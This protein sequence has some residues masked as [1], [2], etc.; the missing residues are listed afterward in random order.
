MGNFVKQ[1]ISDYNFK[2]NY[3]LLNNPFV[4]HE[5]QKFSIVY[6]LLDKSLRFS[7]FVRCITCTNINIHIR[8]FFFH[9]VKIFYNCEISIGAKF[10]L[11]LHFPHP[12]NIIIGGNA[13][14]KNKVVIFHSVTVG[15][16]N[17]GMTGG[18]PSFGNNIV[19]G[20]GSA[21]LGQSNISDNIVIGANSVVTKNVP[22]ESTVVGNNT[23]IQGVYFLNDYD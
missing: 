14:F 5:V 16:K 8:R 1:I 11:A 6:F 3:D 2:R 18:M 21:I 19:I 13:V 9:F 4:D 12:N 23:I 15:K 10:G 22:T 20:S 17:P 7:F